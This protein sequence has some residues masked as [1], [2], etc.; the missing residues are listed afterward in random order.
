MQPGAAPQ[1]P[2]EDTAEGPPL[3]RNKVSAACDV[4]RNK[5]VN[6]ALVVD[7]VRLELKADFAGS[8]QVRWGTA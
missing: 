4:C 3:K 8:D 2:T 7:E 1:A 5:K 6:H